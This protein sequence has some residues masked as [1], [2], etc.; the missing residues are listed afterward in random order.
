MTKIPVFF[1]NLEFFPR[2]SVRSRPFPDPTLELDFPNLFAILQFQNWIWNNSGTN[3]IIHATTFKFSQSITS[4]ANKNLKKDKIQHRLAHA[5][6]HH[7]HEGSAPPVVVAAW[8]FMVVT[9][10]TVARPLRMLTFR[11][12]LVTGV[13]SEGHFAFC[14]VLKF[15]RYT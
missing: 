8:A 2:V 15:P 6:R 4:P 13:S 7:S 14:G 9:S 5:R 12:S 10:V 3:A 11:P 1:R